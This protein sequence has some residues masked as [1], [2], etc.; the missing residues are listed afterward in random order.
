M[1][2]RMFAHEETSALKA[3]RELVASGKGTLHHAVS[4][5]FTIKHVFIFLP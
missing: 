1:L 5:L 3:D 4:I 2:G